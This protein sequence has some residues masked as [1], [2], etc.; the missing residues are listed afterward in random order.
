MTFQ[1]AFIPEED[2]PHHK[3]F[4][5][6]FL[7]LEGVG[8]G[9]ATSHR[10]LQEKHGS[11]K[12]TCIVHH[13]TKKEKMIHPMLHFSSDVLVTFLFMTSVKPRLIETKIEIRR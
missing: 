5:V 13:M 3:D 1:F 6:C 8:Q 9:P 11:G 4:R 7:T 2:V 12:I 10:F